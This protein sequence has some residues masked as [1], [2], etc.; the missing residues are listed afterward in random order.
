M[1]WSATES[2]TMNLRPTALVV[3]TSGLILATG[4]SCGCQVPR[5]VRT[6]E[7]PAFPWRRH[8]EPR[9][10]VPHEHG[11]AETYVPE[12]SEPSRP[13]RQPA[14]PEQPNLRL[15]PEP[16][17]TTEPVPN[18]RPVPVPPALDVE[19]PQ[20]RRWMPSRPSSRWASNSQTRDNEATSDDLSLPPARVT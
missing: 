6:W 20:A 2:F 10:A 5:A 15:P 18:E 13:I 9:L 4:F 11:E 17:I 3:V 7:T 16:S 12:I 19:A 14:T 1:D 8:S